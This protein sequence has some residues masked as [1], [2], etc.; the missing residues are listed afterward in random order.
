M[1]SLVLVVVVVLNSLFALAAL[2]S[3][4]PLIWYQPSSES[5]LGLLL[6]LAPFAMTT[7]Y[8]VVWR[9]AFVWSLA[10]AA[11]VLIALFAIFFGYIIGMLG[12]LST[13]SLGGT[14]IPIFALLAVLAIAN[15]GYL[16]WQ[17][18]VKEPA[19]TNQGIGG[20]S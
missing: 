2:W 6:M 12:G 19:T 13:S 7:L 14:L 5:A 3:M 11:N 8:V 10:L 18:P 1:R 17:R 4:L 16:L 9:T 20:S 15:V